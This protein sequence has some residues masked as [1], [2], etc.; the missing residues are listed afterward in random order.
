M[1]DRKKDQ[2]EQSHIVEPHTKEEQR[3]IAKR[4]GKEGSGKAGRVQH[5]GGASTSHKEKGGKM[6]R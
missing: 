5:K 2:T 6:A 4:Q 3:Q 1:T